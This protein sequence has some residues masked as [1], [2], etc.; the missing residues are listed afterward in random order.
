MEPV[1]LAMDQKSFFGHDD[2]NVILSPKVFFPHKYELKRIVI[3][4]LSLVNEVQF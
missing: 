1:H 2:R 3:K 4:M